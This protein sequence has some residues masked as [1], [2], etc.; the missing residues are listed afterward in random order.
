MLP[1]GS[2]TAPTVLLVAGVVVVVVVVAPLPGIFACAGNDLF[3]VTH[4]AADL[5]LV[6]V[7][8][9]RGRE[10]AVKGRGWR[11]SASGHG[12]QGVLDSPPSVTH[13]QLPSHRTASR[14][15]QRAISSGP[16]FHPVVLVSWGISAMR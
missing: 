16:H 12:A 3:I 9:G 4:E 15:L 1:G 2:D 7:S 10:A 14:G 8:P 13:I 5:N 11:G 6:I